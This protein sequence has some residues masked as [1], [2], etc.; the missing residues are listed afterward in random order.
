MADIKEVILKYDGV[1]I[2]Y[3]ETTYFPN[4]L[5]DEEDGV[6]AVLVLTDEGGW[7]VNFSNDSDDVYNL[8]NVCDFLKHNNFKAIAN[9]QI[10]TDDTSGISGKL[11]LNGTI[12]HSEEDGGLFV[13]DASD[14]IDNDWEKIGERE[15]YECVVHST[16]SPHEVTI[17]LEDGSEKNI[18][19]VNE[20]ILFIEQNT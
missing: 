15:P 6:E 10:E 9:Y 13:K 8:S 11:Y 12:V 3:D 1:Q 18:Q 4:G 20:A 14:V 5:I 17:I 7:S 16:T 2:D 19:A